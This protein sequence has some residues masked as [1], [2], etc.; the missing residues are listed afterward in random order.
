MTAVDSS[1][2]A[3]KKIKHWLRNTG[4]NVNTIV[5]DLAEFTLGFLEKLI[6]KLIHNSRLIRCNKGML[7]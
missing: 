3:M 6:A 2:V 7:C 4:V 1:L 5:A